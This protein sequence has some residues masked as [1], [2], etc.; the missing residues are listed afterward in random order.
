MLM[1]VDEASDDSGSFDEDDDDEGED[2]DELERKAARGEFSLCFLRSVPSRLRASWFQLANELS[3]DD[4]RKDN[5]NGGDSSDD[6]KKK[7]K[8]GRR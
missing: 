3:A 5:G 2:W 6:G 1:S 8:S 7:K 4:K